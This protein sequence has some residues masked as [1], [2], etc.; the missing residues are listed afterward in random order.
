M[1]EEQRSIK[2]QLMLT[3]SEMAAVNEYRWAN[4]LHS[5]AEAIRRLVAAGVSEILKS[6]ATAATVPGSDH[7][8]SPDKE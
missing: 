3:P 8:Q 1:C 5:R 4:R 6:P 7:D 2:F